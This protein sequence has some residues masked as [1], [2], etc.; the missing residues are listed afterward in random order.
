M[1]AMDAWATARDLARLYG[2]APGTIR[3]WAARDRWRRTATRPRRY[4]WEDAQA[5]YERR[6]HPPH[7]P[8]P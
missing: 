6:Y 8:Q 3:S 1:T 5:S 2:V 4:A 7:L